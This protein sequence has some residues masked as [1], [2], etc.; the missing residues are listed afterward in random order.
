MGNN[1]GAAFRLGVKEEAS[2]WQAK[3]GGKPGGP[4]S[5]SH[6]N[7]QDCWALGEFCRETQNGG[8]EDATPRHS[9]HPPGAL[10]LLTIS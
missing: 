2:C 7:H 3:R 9:P 6:L 4:Y 10:R 8:G 5:T 1:R